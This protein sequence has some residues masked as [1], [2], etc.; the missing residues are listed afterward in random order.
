MKSAF[1]FARVSRA[2]REGNKFSPDYQYREHGSKPT[3]VRMPSDHCI[4]FPGRPQTAM[5]LRD[6]LSNASQILDEERVAPTVIY[7]YVPYDNQ[8]GN[9]G[10]GM[11]VV[12][13]L[14]SLAGTVNISN[15]RNQ[16]P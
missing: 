16:R 4:V 1:L 9:V 14:A 6:A 11:A 12:Q 15:S 7:H 2:V 8:A 10:V 3:R 13:G 5:D